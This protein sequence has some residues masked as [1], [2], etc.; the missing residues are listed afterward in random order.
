MATDPSKAFDP[1]PFKARL[2]GAPIDI[3]PAEVGAEY[4]KFVTPHDDRVSHD[5]DGRP[6]I[7]GR[8][9]HVDREGHI[10]VMVAD[11]EDEE[12]MTS[13]RGD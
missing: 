2:H 8:E 5:A 1:S 9:Y 11:A 7:L 13:A 12:H 10:T 3:K 6:Y 4:P